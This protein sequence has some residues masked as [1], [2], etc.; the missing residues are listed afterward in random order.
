MH[1]KQMSQPSLTKCITVLKMRARTP[2]HMHSF[3][4]AKGQQQQQQAARREEP[5]GPHLGVRVLPRHD[6]ESSLQ[7]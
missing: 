2:W 6:R 7:D 5:R 1:G 4:M 3:S